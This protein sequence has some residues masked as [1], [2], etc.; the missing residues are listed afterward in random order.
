MQ[1]QQ[2]Q[3]LCAG[4][5]VSHVNTEADETHFSRHLFF[6]SFLISTV[7]CAVCPR[8]RLY[9]E[10]PLSAEELEDVFDSLDTGRNGYLTLEAFSSGFSR[11]PLRRR[12][13]AR[14]SHLKHPPTHPKKLCNNV[15]SRT[16]AT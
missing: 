5:G 9:R 11:C 12:A 7:F 2:Q 6:W 16:S 8:Q 15:G 4:Q 1:Q 14:F 10:L 3:P 13:S